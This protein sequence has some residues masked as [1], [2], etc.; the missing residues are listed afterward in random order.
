L[1]GLA[2]VPNVPRKND[3]LTPFTEQRR[4]HAWCAALSV[5]VPDRPPW[6]FRP[7]HRLPRSL[8][9]PCPEPH[10]RDQPL[11]FEALNARNAGKSTI[12][13]MSTPACD[14]TGG[15]PQ[16]TPFPIAKS[17]SQTRWPTQVPAPA[18]RTRLGNTP[19]AELDLGVRATGVGWLLS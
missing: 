7:I 17:A 5:P 4:K 12:T 9:H 10:E 19:G 2:A 8:S 14:P 13:G 16:P 18:A 11:Q 3:P 1:A 15:M 6:V